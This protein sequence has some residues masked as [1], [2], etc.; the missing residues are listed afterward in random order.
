MREDGSVTVSCYFNLTL[1]AHLFHLSL[2]VTALHRGATHLV[3]GPCTGELGDLEHSNINVGIFNM[4]L[5]LVGMISMCS[6]FS[7]KLWK[8][9]PDEDGVG[10][11]VGGFEGGSDEPKANDDEGQEQE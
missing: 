2:P 4:A 3:V 8:A 5:S 1:C 10:E 9:T 11:V 7:S 6:S